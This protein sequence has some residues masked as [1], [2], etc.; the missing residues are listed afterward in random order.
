[1]STLICI[2]DNPDQGVLYLLTGISNT[3]LK[4]FSWENLE[5][6]LNLMLNMITILS[7]FKQENYLYHIENGSL[8]IKC[9][10]NNRYY[11]LKI[12]NFF[13]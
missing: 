5:I 8:L 7:A 11:L 2:P 13:S 6:K 9:Y 10:L 12:I 3:I 4:H 1:M